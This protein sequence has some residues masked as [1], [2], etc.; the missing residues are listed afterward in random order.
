MRFHTDENVS[1]AVALGLRRRG[2]DVTTTKEAGLR[3]VTDE[4]QLAYALRESRVMISHDADML[5]LASAGAP[6]AGL[7]YCHGQKYKV[8]QLLLKLLALAGR[9]PPQ[10]M[11]GRVEFL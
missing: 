5:R 4:D 1:E 10:A 11:Q 8:G 7:T 3:G 6:H 2:F 9:L